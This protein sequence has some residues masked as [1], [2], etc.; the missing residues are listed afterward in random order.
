MIGYPAKPMGRYGIPIRVEIADVASLIPSILSGYGYVVT[1]EG[2]KDVFTCPTKHG[3]ARFCIG[4]GVPQRWCASLS[5][6]NKEIAATLE[7]AGIFM[8][9]DEYFAK[10][11]GR[12]GAG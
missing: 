6:S 2:D 10:Y 3:Q 1:K 8:E 9:S 5:P 7:Q 12:S 4:K 11:H